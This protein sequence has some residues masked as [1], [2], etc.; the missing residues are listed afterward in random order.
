MFAFLCITAHAQQQLAAPPHAALGNSS[1]A[2]SSGNISEQQIANRLQS[3]AATVSPELRAYA[4]EQLVDLGVVRPYRDRKALLEEAFTLA[5]LSPNALK[6]QFVSGNL[7]SHAGYMSY[8][9]SL[10]LDTL[11]LESHA[12]IEMT[13][14][15][16]AEAQNMF[17]DMRIPR[18]KPVNCSSGLVYDFSSYFKMVEALYVSD[19]NIKGEREKAPYILQ[20]VLSNLSSST[21]VSPAIRLISNLKL[22]GS[23][24]EEAEIALA[25]AFNQIDADD[26]SFEYSFID[27]VSSLYSV[28]DQNTAGFRVLLNAVRD[29]VV[30]SLS[31]N[32]CGNDTGSARLK[33]GDESIIGTSVKH[34]NGLNALLKANGLDVIEPDEIVPASIDDAVRSNGEEYWTTAPARGLELAF[35]SLRTDIEK[36]SDQPSEWQNEGQ[37]LLDNLRSWSRPS[38]D[39]ASADWFMQKALLYYQLV[40]VIPRA[41]IL[42]PELLTDYITFL[43]E[44]PNNRE[45]ELFWLWTVVR[46]INHTDETRGHQKRTAIVSALYQVNNPSITVLLLITE[47]QSGDK[48]NQVVAGPLVHDSR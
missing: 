28:P 6:V 34:L 48:R 12:V 46:A 15:D 27:I 10:E 35:R 40:I 30:R 20:R 42:Y 23:R 1:L 24:R 8:A 14:V 3:L 32:V 44:P 41:S 39:T 13:K 5:T 11:S 33:S 47:L 38:D 26:R 9:S 16:V 36:E 18:A 17:T 25:H 29:Y 21:E 37:T 4:L 22:Q 19:D 45:T 2:P 7:D 43:A 31:G